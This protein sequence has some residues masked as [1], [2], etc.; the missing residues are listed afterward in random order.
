MKPIVPGGNQAVMVVG[1]VHMDFGA[2]NTLINKKQPKIILQCG[3]FGYWPRATTEEIHGRANPKYP[4]DLPRPKVPEGCTVHWIDG[5]HEE[6]NDLDKRSSNEVWPRCYYQPRGSHIT[7]PDGRRV[8]FMGGAASHDKQWRTPQYDWFPQETVSETDYNAVD[9]TLKYDI[10]ISHTCPK[11]FQPRIFLLD[12]HGPIDGRDTHDPSEHWLDLIW[13]RVKPD[14]WFFGHWHRCKHGYTDNTRWQ[15]LDHTAGQGNW[16]GWL[17]EAKIPHCVSEWTKRE[18]LPQLLEC[19]IAG[20]PDE[21]NDALCGEEPAL[22]YIMGQA[23]WA[24]KGVANPKDV[25][26]TLRWRLEI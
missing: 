8:L 7:L 4:K 19:L 17:E 24:S 1:D 14:L 11:S 6:H 20:Y 25:M 13:Q 9:F 23:M 16:W 18:R 10:V 12:R 3:D 26:E 15:V 21:W 22:R 5:N 2:L